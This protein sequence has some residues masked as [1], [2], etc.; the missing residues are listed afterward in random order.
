MVT[1]APSWSRRSSALSVSDYSMNQKGD[2]SH[3]V[4]FFCLWCDLTLRSWC[5]QSAKCKMQNVVTLS[6][7]R[8]F[9]LLV[10]SKLAV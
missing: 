10:A 3:A 2:R 7:L 5:G 8:S 9:G 4:A 1:P 6:S